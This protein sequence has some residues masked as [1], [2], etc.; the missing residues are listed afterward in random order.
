[1]PIYTIEDFANHVQVPFLV[2]FTRAQNLPSI[3]EYGIVPIAL[4]GDFGL[5]P[6][7]NDPER[8]D[9]YPDAT[10]TSIGFPNYRMFFQLRTSIAGSQWAVLMLHRSILWAKRCAF[11]RTNAA[12]GQISAQPREGLMML[13]AF[14]GMY[15]QVVGSESRAEQRL[16]SYDPTDV[17]A[18]VLVFDVIEPELIHGIAFD[19]QWVSAQYQHLTVGKDVRIYFPGSGPFAQRGSSYADG[20]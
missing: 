3:L 14:Q 1:M 13:S 11:C 12:N 16:R 18:E 8:Y 20:F 15:E 19:S 10:C 17:Q 5:R 2:H 7:V 4:C 6:V 9:G